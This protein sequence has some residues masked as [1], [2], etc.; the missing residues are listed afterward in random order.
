VAAFKQGLI[1]VDKSKSLTR[2]LVVQAV[3][4]YQEQELNLTVHDFP[5]QCMSD[6]KLDRLLKLSLKAEKSLFA[7]SYTAERESEHIR[8]FE[9]ARQEKK[10]CSIDTK[11]VLEDKD[12]R[13]FFA[14][15]SK[16]VSGPD[17]ISR[18]PLL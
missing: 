9:L 7:D 1:V 17:S 16:R 4:H 11:Q 5:L 12:W 18:V 15:L 8:G 14:S 13:L 6:L 10:Y 3:R 2:P